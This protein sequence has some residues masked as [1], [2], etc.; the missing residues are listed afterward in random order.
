VGA[1]ILLARRC[2]WRRHGSESSRE[3][4]LE[5]LASGRELQNDG[6]VVRFGLLVDQDITRYCY[7]RL[8]RLKAAVKDDKIVDALVAELDVSGATGT[9]KMALIERRIEDL[10]RTSSMWHDVAAPE[11]LAASIFKSHARIG[12]CVDDLFGRVRRVQ[13]L[14]APL[15]AWLKLADLTPYE[16]NVP[17]F[18]VG[19]VIGYRG[20]HSMSAVRLVGIEA[21]N[22]AADLERALEEMKTAKHSTHASYVAC[23]PA[24]AAEF[25]WTQAAAP[26]AHRWDAEA[27][28]RRLQAS[29]CGLLLVEGDAVSHALPA[30]ER[31][32]DVA[33]LAELSAAI[34]RTNTIAR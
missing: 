29:A 34:R 25:L 5:A 11:I 28:R 21:T 18:G 16:G 7:L 9:G 10:R 14:A 24:V 4:L 31:R 20:G 1:G 12:A 6:R 27:L 19:N 22:D 30:K 17:G 8:R 26:G 13:D 23:T 3:S 15:V 33:K 32:P 2:L